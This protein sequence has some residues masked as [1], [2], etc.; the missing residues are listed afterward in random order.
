MDRRGV[1]NHFEKGR[2][3][4][5]FHRL[6]SVSHKLKSHIMEN[7]TYCIYAHIFPDGTRYIGMTKNAKNRWYLSAYKGV[8]PFYSRACEIGFDNLEHVILIEGLTKEEAM[9]REHDIIEQYLALGQCCNNMLG[10]N[11]SEKT[12]KLFSEERKGERHY[13]FGKHLSDA[14][15]QKISNGNRGKKMSLESRKKMGESR[16]GERNGMFGKHHSEETRRKIGE[17]TK[18][19]HIH[20]QEFIQG[21]IARNK[22]RLKPIDQYALDGTFL[23]HWN[24]VT[25]AAN[26]TGIKQSSI[27]ENLIGRKKTAKGFIWKY[28]IN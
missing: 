24:S 15:R 17:A 21:V 13:L 12:R 8:E 1:A 23:K 25:E 20:T 7:T 4:G 22:Q 11:H 27:S 6:F 18:G 2:L 14:T 3:T 16:S 5:P 19:K 28:A 10:H 9:K 26:E